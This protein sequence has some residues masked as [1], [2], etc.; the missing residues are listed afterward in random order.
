MRTVHLDALSTGILPAV[1]PLE[2][3]PGHVIEGTAQFRK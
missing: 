3:S 1:C 2:H